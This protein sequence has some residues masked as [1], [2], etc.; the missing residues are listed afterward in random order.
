MTLITDKREI[1]I[2]GEETPRGI[3]GDL[4]GVRTLGG[5]KEFTILAALASHPGEVYSRDALLSIS[6]TWDAQPQVISVYLSRLRA[7]IGDVVEIVNHRNY[8]WSLHERASSAV[9]LAGSQPR[10][11][12]VHAEAV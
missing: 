1:W 3:G 12:A 2:D 7:G 9:A 8:G 6:D 10:R 4:R 5:G 11:A